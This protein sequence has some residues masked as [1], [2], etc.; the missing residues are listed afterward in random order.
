MQD[1]ERAQRLL[2]DNDIQWVQ[3][4]FV[5][6]VGCLRTFSMPATSYFESTIWKEGVGFDGSSVKGFATV[7]SSDMVIIPDPT[8]LLPLPW[9]EDGRRARIIMDVFDA[10]S[11]EH[12]EGDPRHIA[13]RA[14][15]RVR[16]MGYDSLHLSPEF[17]FHVW[18]R[19]RWPED[20]ARPDLCP[21]L[22][23]PVQTGGYFAPL[24]L[25]RGESFRNHLA[26]ALMASGVEVKYHHHEGGTWQH[27]V[28]IRPLG[29]AVQAADVT[30]LF[31]FMAQ[32]LGFQ[33]D[34][35]V[36]FMPKPV[37][38]EAGSG[39]HVHLEL[40]RGGTCV[41]Y[42]PDEEHHLSQTARYFIGGI[43]EHAP[44]MTALTNPTVNSYKRLV[45][46]HE[47]PIHITWGVYNRS[48]LVRIPNQ[49]GKNRSVD[50]EVRHPD[51]SANPYLAFAAIVHA[52]LEGVRHQ[53]EPGPPIEKN[54]YA[55][56]DRQL[57]EHGVGMLPRTLGE[58][59]EAL[60]S[61]QVMQDAL[62][63]VAAA[64]F[65]DLKQREWQDFLTHISSWEYQRYLTV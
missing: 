44:A 64:A 49:T 9:L 59:L 48:S 11:R 3:G 31:K 33:H 62:G 28:E 39:M 37:P 46:H 21:A 63:P 43:L 5:D 50:I 52:G 7:E 58:A 51:P 16:D 42:D 12:F 19:K 13:R 27:E 8:T 23:D 56:D 6:L 57:K 60:H 14:A 24:P 36:S 2:K 25:D 65:L 20:G 35:L 40:F 55:L 47:A 41:F 15:H 26:E 22:W 54:T 4:H 10:A 61:D 53:R 1:V 34:L 30:T 32:A 29:D 38:G 45:P 18:E 17:E